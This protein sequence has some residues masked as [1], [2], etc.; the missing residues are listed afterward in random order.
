[1]RTPYRIDVHATGFIPKGPYEQ[2]DL[3]VQV[4]FAFEPAANG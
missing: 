2:R 4:S 3:S 1:V